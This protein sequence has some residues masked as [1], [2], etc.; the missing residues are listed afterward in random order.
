MSANKQHK[1][2]IKARA[3]GTSQDN[4]VD[5]T[6]QNG[7]SDRPDRTAGGPLPRHGIPGYP[8][9]PGQHNIIP[10]V[11]TCT[12][13]P[14]PTRTLFAHACSHRG[15][16]CIVW[17]CIPDVYT[18]L[19]FTVQLC[20]TSLYITHVDVLYSHHGCLYLQCTCLHCVCI[21]GSC[22]SECLYC[23]CKFLYLWYLRWRFLRCA[24]I[25]SVLKMLV[26]VTLVDCLHTLLTRAFLALDLLTHTLIVRTLIVLLAW[27]LI[28]HT[29]Y[30]IS[31]THR[32]IDRT[33]MVSL[34]P[35][36]YVHLYLQL[37]VS[38]CLCRYLSRICI[39]GFL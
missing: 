14:L 5:I 15:N 11:S 26:L 7:R 17:I 38:R 1:N 34:Y 30:H 13:K 20:I 9:V 18:L 21:V 2:Q 25:V 16:L 12:T 19:V 32:V 39:C 37:L 22:I 24:L 28:A 6:L 3:P 27:A 31:H 29:W 36:H 4:T 23:I 35:T 8:A 33:Q 10:H